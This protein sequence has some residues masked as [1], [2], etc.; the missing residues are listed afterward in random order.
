MKS[1]LKNSYLHL[2]LRPKFSNPILMTP[3]R[4]KAYTILLITSII[5]GVASP[6]IKFTLN[7][8]DPLPFLSYRFF[9]AGVAGLIVIGINHKELVK[10]LKNFPQVFIFS[11][12]ATTISLGLLFVG[13]N[14]TTVLDAVLISAVSPL[15]TAAFGYYFLQEN[16]TKQE[17]LG[18]TIAFIGTI[19]TIMEPILKGNGGNY[20]QITGNLLVVGYLFTN[21]YS[22]VVAKKLSRKGVGSFA[23]SN[24]SFLI[25]FVTIL[26]F[27]LAKTPA[28]E[29]VH[30]VVTLEFPYHLGVWYMAFLSG[31]IAYAMWIKGQKAIEISE[32]GVFAYLVPIFAAPLAVLWLGETITTPFI[33]GAIVIAI[34]VIIAE[35]KGKTT[36]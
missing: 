6:I 15:V 23:M 17:R 26:P 8:I 5:W 32:A 27:T 1:S 30:Q 2:I 10:I 14:Q 16:I 11:T 34:G 25:G 22:A 4:I 28:K 29:I 9:L 35:Y 7:G 21:A 18:M 33:I 31:T 24:V 3:A 19:I 36:G 12:F 13:M 20:F